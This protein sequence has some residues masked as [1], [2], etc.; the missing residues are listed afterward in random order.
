VFIV[1]P[2][3]YHTIQNLALVLYVLQLG[4]EPESGVG[5]LGFNS[6]EWVLSSM[7]AIFAG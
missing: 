4:L 7:G 1:D 5:I 2:S 6:P 3:A